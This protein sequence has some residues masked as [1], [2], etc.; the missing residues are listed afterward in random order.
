M[1]YRKLISAAAKSMQ[2]SRTNLHSLHEALNAQEQLALRRL[3]GL[4][5]LC[6]ESM[7]LGREVCEAEI[8]ALV[9][10]L[11]GG[12]QHNRQPAH[13]AVATAAA[14][15]GLRISLSSS[16]LPDELLGDSNSEDSDSDGSEGYNDLDDEDVDTGL[17]SSSAESDDLIAL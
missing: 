15:D 1:E 9:A 2:Q 5:Y 14:V 4:E 13:A 3:Q 11:E 17:N 7:T 16:A 8:E 6:R 10:R 12:N